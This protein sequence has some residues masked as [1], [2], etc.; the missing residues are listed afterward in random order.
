MSIGLALGPST[1]HYLS[2]Q[3]TNTARIAATKISA[4][5]AIAKKHLYIPTLET[6][7]SDSL[8]FYSLGVASVKDALEAAYALGLATA[9]TRARLGL[10]KAK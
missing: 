8:D 1:A 3:P 9:E 4:L 2:M 6:R 10:P 5:S 7:N